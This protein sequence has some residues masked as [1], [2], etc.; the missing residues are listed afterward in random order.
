MKF[1]IVVALTF[2]VLCGACGAGLVCCS[3]RCVRETTV[4]RS[5][6]SAPGDEAPG[7]GPSC[8]GH[9]DNRCPSTPDKP[10]DLPTC[11][12]DLRAQA[13]EIEDLGQQHV[14]KRLTVRGSIGLEATTY[15]REPDG[16][17][18]KIS[19]NEVYRSKQCAPGTCCLRCETGY[20]IGGP[21]A[22]MAG[23]IPQEYP[24][25]RIAKGANREYVC[26]GDESQTCC[27]IMQIGDVLVTGVLRK[28]NERNPAWRL[29]E[30]VMCRLR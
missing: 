14:G 15:C 23:T 4:G 29:D 2:V 26:G 22:H 9:F 6:E 5:A 24:K 25:V 11:D 8:F 19:E 20:N 30:P 16:S 10:K 13:V 7:W 28:T 27:S 3:N 21:T 18:R 17:M 1:R 12:A